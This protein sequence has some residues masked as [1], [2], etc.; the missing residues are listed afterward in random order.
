MAQCKYI[1]EIGLNH[2]GSVPF[3][4]SLLET[5][6]SSGIE[7]ITCQIRED[8]FFDGSEPWRVALNQQE[9]LHLKAVTNRLDM[10]FGLSVGDLITAQKIQAIEPDFWKVLSFGS[11]DFEL[12]K[13]LME[14]GKPVYA[15]T[16]NIDLEML[17]K[18]V[19]QFDGI[20]L[21]H[22]EV[23]PNLS[24]ANLKALETI[25]ETVAC[26]V[27]YGLH[28]PDTRLLYMALCYSPDRM[29]FYVKGDS[30]HS[31]P[32]DEHA[33][34]TDQV[35]SLVEGLKD[36]EQAVGDGIKVSS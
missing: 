32:D 18:I 5:L 13:F 24:A 35:Q 3:A 19:D 22:T 33:V 27:S 17:S 7:G 26:P 12:L 9:H 28:A 30:N 36:L 11:T 34:P 14:S 6:A 21:I 23:T 10:K 4:E 29:F 1:A 2:L 15:S 20:R 8:E 16:G 31:Y 25:Q